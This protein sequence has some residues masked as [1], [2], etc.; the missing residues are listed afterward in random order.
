[1]HTTTRGDANITLGQML[2]KGSFGA[3]FEAQSN[4]FATKLVAKRGDRRSITQEFSIA[5]IG[6]RSLLELY[7]AGAISS[8]TL[9]D[10]RSLIF[11]FG[12]T[13]DGCAVERRVPGYTVEDAI[14]KKM[15][16][17]DEQG[18]PVNLREALL[19]SSDFYRVLADLHMLGL[20]FGDTHPGNIMIKVV[21][22]AQGQTE[23]TICLVDFGLSL[24]TAE[25]VSGQ[26]TILD[27][28]I[29]RR[30]ELHP[31]KSY[32]TR[33]QYLCDQ[34]T[35]L[36][37]VEVTLQE[38]INAFSE[39]FGE[40]PSISSYDIHESASILD[41]LLFGALRVCGEDYNYQYSREEAQAIL[42]EQ[43]RGYP[44]LVFGFINVLLQ[45]M[46]SDDPGERPS[47]EIIA[48]ILQILA[49]APGELLQAMIDDVSLENRIGG[50]IQVL[51]EVIPSDDPMLV[52]VFAGDA[53]SEYPFNEYVAIALAAAYGDRERIQIMQEIN[54]FTRYSAAKIA[55]A[56]IFLIESIHVIQHPDAADEL[57]QLHASLDQLRAELAAE[58]VAEPVAEP[59]AELAAELAAGLP[60]GDV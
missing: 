54:P 3:V 36:K 9:Q 52:P 55:Q 8:P 23:H 19:L 60:E 56:L 31:D 57:A 7:R 6:L 29:A 48:Q 38:K 26:L 46:L 20:T 59:V 25:T 10:F 18:L 33:L 58:L 24:P 45:A 49:H 51:I 11:P 42:N 5:Q 37:T 40:N 16:P 53:P 34:R 43:K 17:Y 2:G 12:M 47:A 21:T 32:D 22:N 35:E 27:N 28:E 44:P 15:T 39:P 30:R 41:M 14:D 1:M 50:T 4:K 13:E